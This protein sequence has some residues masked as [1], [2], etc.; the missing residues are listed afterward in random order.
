VTGMPHDKIVSAA[1]IVLS[2]VLH[3]L[4]VSGVDKCP[5]FQCPSCPSCPECP[6]PP[7][8]DNRLLHF[9]WSVVLVVAVLTSFFLGGVLFTVQ[10]DRDPASAETSKASE[11]SVS[12]ASASVGG[13]GRGKGI[14]KTL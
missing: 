3:H 13:K 7:P 14:V 11:S 8:A 1:V 12:S 9:V 6:P 5:V 10:G 2:N 4:A